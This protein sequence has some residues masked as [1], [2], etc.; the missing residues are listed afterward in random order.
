[1][2]ARTGS[3]SARADERRFS[4]MIPAPSPRTYPFA[5]ESNAL[6]RP[7]GAMAPALVKLI[8]MAGVRIRFTPPARASV[9]SPLHRLWHARWTATSEDEHA[10]STAKLGPL[11][12]REYESR[13]AAML[14]ALPVPA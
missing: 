10:V 12:S 13:F 5:L 7:S 3:P 6:Q 2:T 11:K 14:I 1:M 4:T 8:A 9:H